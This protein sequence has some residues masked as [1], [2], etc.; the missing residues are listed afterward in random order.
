MQFFFSF[1][2]DH[3]SLELYPKYGILITSVE[4]DKLHVSGTTLFD[5]TS[6]QLVQGTIER[7]DLSKMQLYTKSF[8]LLVRYMKFWLQHCFSQLLNICKSIFI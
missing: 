5:L 2:A 7:I 4:T 1:S 6:E 3:T 8:F